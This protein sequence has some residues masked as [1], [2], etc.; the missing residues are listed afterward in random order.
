M[1]KIL[2]IYKS[3]LINNCKI[4][5]NKYNRNKIKLIKIIKIMNN[6]FKILKIKLK[7]HKQ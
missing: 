7:S 4:R 1:K 6:K 3:N 5:K 2:I